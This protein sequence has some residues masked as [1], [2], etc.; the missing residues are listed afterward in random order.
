MRIKDALPYQ[1]AE[2]ALSRGIHDQLAFAWWIL[3]TIKNQN[4]IISMLQVPKKMMKYGYKFL[5]VLI[6]HMNLTLKITMISGVEQSK[7]SSTM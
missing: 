7:R 6:K 1:L 5:G 3:K 4:K 2:Y